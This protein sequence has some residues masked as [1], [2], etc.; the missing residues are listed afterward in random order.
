MFDAVTL[1]KYCGVV[2]TLILAGFGLP[3]PEEIP[4]VTAGAMV[5]N[6]AREVADYRRLD[7]AYDEFDERTDPI[8]GVVGGWIDHTRPPKPERPAHL[9]RWWIMLPAIIVAVV[10]GD[11][12]LYTFGRIGGRRLLQVGWVQRRILPPEKQVKIEENFHKNGILIL[13]GARLT[14]GIRTPVFVMAGVLKMPLSRFLLADG[15][16]AIPGVNL[17]FWIAYLFT[18]QFVAAVEAAERH[19]PM[20]AVAILAAIGGVVLYKML[21]NRTLSTGDVE[22]IPTYVKPVGKVTHAVEQAVEMAVGKTVQVS[23]KAAAAVVDKV[24]HPLGHKTHTPHEPPTVEPSANGQPTASEGKPVEHPA[25]TD[26]SHPT[27]G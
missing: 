15:L 13:L 23:A 9:T 6:D 2:G 14:P 1:W 12:I 19:K 4:I 10:L 20:V 25:P 7:D 26:E 3:I 18:D 8:A 21:A 22:E 17:L 27:P 5:G 11:C 24:T 16:Y